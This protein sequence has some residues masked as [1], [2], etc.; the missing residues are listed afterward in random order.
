MTRSHLDFDA[1]LVDLV[2]WSPGSLLPSLLSLSLLLALSPL[3][4]FSWPSSVWAILDVSGYPPPHIY[5]KPLQPHLRPSCTPYLLQKRKFK[6][7]TVNLT[8]SSWFWRSQTLRKNLLLLTCLIALLTNW[9]L[10]SC[11]YNHRLVLPSILTR[12]TF[13]HKEQE[14]CRDYKLSSVSQISEHSALNVLCQHHKGPGLPGRDGGSGEKCCLLHGT[15]IA[16][17]NSHEPATASIG[18]THRTERAAK[19]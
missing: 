13:P 18:S 11:V 1:H 5:N 14:S 15:A 2:S 12:G 7:G 6:S 3:S 4:I 17:M 10:N 19:I 8:K 9:L 16:L